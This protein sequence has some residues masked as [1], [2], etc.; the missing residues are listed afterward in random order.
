MNI[1]KRLENKDY[2]N[3]ELVEWLE[4]S[5]PI[6]FYL[7]ITEIVTN[8]IKD[9]II[10]D[11]L[12]ELSQKLDNNN[13]ILGYYKKGHLAMSALF[14]LG[15]DSDSVFTLDLDPFE[16]EMTLKFFNENDW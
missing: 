2:M 14:K 4:N 12:L 10:I 1:K 5:N 9:Q 6:L 8:H 15:L 11:K 13:K 16:K 3:N 7:V